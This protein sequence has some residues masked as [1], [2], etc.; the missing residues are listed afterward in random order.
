MSGQ[1]VEEFD[2][3]PSTWTEGQAPPP[4]VAQFDQEPKRPPP[5]L[6]T[7]L[8]LGV[9]LSLV[10]LT[11]GVVIGLLSDNTPPDTLIVVLA[12]VFGVAMGAIA[13]GILLEE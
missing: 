7:I 8:A 3:P 12:A 6:R 9:A 5:S 10:I 11:L 1:D 13:T 2:V 4:P